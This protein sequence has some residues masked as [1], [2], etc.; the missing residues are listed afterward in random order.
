V[1]S[2]QSGQPGA[3]SYALNE[4]GWLDEQVVAAGQLRQGKAPTMAQMMIGVGVLWEIWRPRRFKGLPRHFVMAVTPTQVHAFKSVG[5]SPENSSQYTITI[6]DGV[7][8]TFPRASVSMSDVPEGAQSKGGILAIDGRQFPVMRPNMT[9]D[10]NTDELIALL[11]GLSAQ[12]GEPTDSR[13]G[14]IL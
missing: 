4:S 6:F 9:G 1:I 12:D 7:D 5:G 2:V 8:A 11:A 3:L 14:L 10:P 13:D